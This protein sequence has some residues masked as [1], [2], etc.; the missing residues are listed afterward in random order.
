[1][2]WY[3]Y[4]HTPARSVA[5]YCWRR[6]VCPAGWALIALPGRG[7]LST[8]AGVPHRGGAPRGA[9][10]APGCAASQCGPGLPGTASAD[11]VDGL[12]GSAAC[13]RSL[14]RGLNSRLRHWQE[15]FLPLGH[16]ISLDFSPDRHVGVPRRVPSLLCIVSRS[17]HNGFLTIFQILSH[18]CI[19]GHLSWFIS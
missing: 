10:R 13:E 5:S 16:Q 9:A 3:T 6:H 4:P 14:D 1:M 17:I 15:G 19:S 12:S 18:T 11:M 7:L 2:Q 8:A